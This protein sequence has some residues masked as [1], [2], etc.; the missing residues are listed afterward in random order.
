MY[1]YIYNT[2]YHRSAPDG[3]HTSSVHVTNADVP[4]TCT[5]MSDGVISVPL[6]TWSRACHIYIYIY[7]ER[8]GRV[9]LTHNAYIMLCYHI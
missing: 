8:G 2:V 4:R 3:A 6:N 7:L 9:T 5:R 1:I